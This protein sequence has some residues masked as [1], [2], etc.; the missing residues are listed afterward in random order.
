MTEG[1]AAPAAGAEQGRNLLLRIGAA[2]VTLAV[3]GLYVEWLMIV[4]AVQQTRV[5]ASGIANS[6]R[7]SVFGMRVVSQ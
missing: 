4:G 6:T 7:R 5:V 2:L 1:E 3:I